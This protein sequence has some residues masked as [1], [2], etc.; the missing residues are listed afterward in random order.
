MGAAKK[1][2]WLLVIV[3]SKDNMKE[4]QERQCSFLV[5]SITRLTAVPTVN[6]M[7][8]ATPAAIKR[9]KEKH[10]VTSE[11]ATTTVLRLLLPQQNPVIV[12]DR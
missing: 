5:F 12:D 1:G 10:A 4:V 7:I 2:D 3:E 8:T 11:L 9:Q 6:F